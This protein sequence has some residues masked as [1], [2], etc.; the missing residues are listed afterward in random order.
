MAVSDYL[1][2][3]LIH[4]LVNMHIV[5][6]EGLK[7]LW[8]KNYR[9]CDAHSENVIMRFVSEAKCQGL[10]RRQGTRE[11]ALS[12]VFKD[13]CVDW[14]T[15]Y[16]VLIDPF[17]MT[18]VVDTRKAVCRGLKDP[19]KDRRMDL[20]RIFQIWTEIK[21]DLIDYL[22]HIPL[23]GEISKAIGDVPEALSSHDEEDL[24]DI[25]HKRLNRLRME[26]DKRAERMFRGESDKRAK[27]I[28]E[29]KKWSR[30][31]GIWATV[32]RDAKNVYSKDDMD[33][34]RLRELKQVRKSRGSDGSRR[35]LIASTSSLK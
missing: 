1:N 13:K 14:N 31:F 10:K 16:L 32:P 22:P 4:Q 6:M 25:I 17:Y 35:T 11:S 19:A 7:D 5:Y 20:N 3:L 21:K 18:K 2:V 30:N 8:D 27:E 23:V 33:I 9:H 34:E 26:Y 28:K 24:Y 12:D 15:K 29:N